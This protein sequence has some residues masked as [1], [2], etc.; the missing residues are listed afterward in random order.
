M[1]ELLTHSLSHLHTKYIG[2]KTFLNVLQTIQQHKKRTPF[3]HLHNRC[4][5]IT[6]SSN[7]DKTIYPLSL[8][9][10]NTCQI[11]STTFIQC[12]RKEKKNINKNVINQYE[13]KFLC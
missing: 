10:C 5:L 8:N 4:I 11:H 13:L 3:P 12:S 7:Y 9:N 1:S 2:E 6:A